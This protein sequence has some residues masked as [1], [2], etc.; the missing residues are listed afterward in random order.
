MNEEIKNI[1]NKA[2]AFYK[3][4][5]FP[6][7]IQLWQKALE[8][9]PHEIEVLYSLGIINFELKK[10]H[11]AIEFLLRVLELSPGHH[12]AMLIIGTSYIKLRKFDLA[13]EYIQNSIEINPKQKLAYLNL[14]AIYSVQKKFEEG[15]RMFTKVIEEHP[16]EIRA[17]FG[18][19]KIH[20]ILGNPEEANHHF[21]KVIELNPDGA[22]GAAA[23]KAL[24]LYESAPKDEKDL[25]QFYT[26]GYRYLING[27]YQHAISKFESYLVN[28]PNDH[29]VNFLLAE[30]QLRSGLLKKSFLSFK[31]A[32]LNNPKS[33]LYYKELGILLD[34]I[35]N[36]NDVLEILF[37]A[38]EFGKDDSL[39]N[40]L[41]G[42][43]LLRINRFQEG[44]AKLKKAIKQ[45][46]NNLAARY[47]LIKNYLKKGESELAQEQVQF[48]LDFPL[49]TPYKQ[50]VNELILDSV[51]K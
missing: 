1:H 29:L 6:Q 34:K 14:G 42:K 17:H 51:D 2:I 15:I 20:N 27:H 30:G 48:I 37:K 35:G 5:K 7:A 22:L 36:A 46:R 28:R 19:A 31:K 12:K 18:L 11:E 4:K 44:I 50:A 3:E 41:L 10:Y 45:D 26:T 47:E 33:G 23:K 40:Y 13:E 24:L 25:E 16:S 9:N 21:R 39:V 8:V 43:N 49:E 38:Q 32:I